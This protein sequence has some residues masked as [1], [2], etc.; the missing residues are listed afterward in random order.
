MESMENVVWLGP[1][2]PIYPPVRQIVRAVTP[3]GLVWSGY[4]EQWNK[5]FRDR[6]QCFI[7][8]PNGI[9]IVPG[10]YKARLVGNYSGL[11]LYV[12]SLACCQPMSFFVGSSS[13]SAA[14]PG[15]PASSVSTSPPSMSSASLGIEYYCLSGG[16]WYCLLPPSK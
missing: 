10:S 11:P 13:S 12:L 9:Q 6:E 15:S 2:F 16:L 8:E 1:G 5:G 3:A 4:T 14:S 7:Y